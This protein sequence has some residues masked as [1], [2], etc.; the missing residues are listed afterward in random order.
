MA[1][2][3]F[4]EKNYSSW[5]IKWNLDT[6]NKFWSTN[7]SEE[8]IEMLKDYEKPLYIFIGKNYQNRDT[9]N[10][11]CFEEYYKRD[12]TEIYEFKC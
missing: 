7:S 2:R 1:F 5:L 8:A 11:K 6:W 9:F 3:L 4:K 10:D 12:K